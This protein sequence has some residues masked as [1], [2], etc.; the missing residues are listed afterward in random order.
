MKNRAM[1][2]ARRR[3]AVRRAQER[4]RHLQCL[5][6]CRIREAARRHLCAHIGGLGNWVY[7]DFFGE[8]APFHPT[9]ERQSYDWDEV[10]NRNRQSIEAMMKLNARLLW[11]IN[12]DHEEMP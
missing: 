7:H 9:K 8:F 4:Q 6:R 10:F 12:N 2:Q 11:K 5:I 1:R 3:A